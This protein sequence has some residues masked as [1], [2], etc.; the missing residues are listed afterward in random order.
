MGQNRIAPGQ[1]TKGSVQGKE[2]HG[3]NNARGRHAGLRRGGRRKPTLIAQV[4]SSHV[5]RARGFLTTGFGAGI[6]APEST[7]S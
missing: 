4:Y 7:N 5:P 3:F 2:L 6:P 1:R